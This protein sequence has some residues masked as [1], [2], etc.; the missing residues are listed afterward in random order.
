MP[1]YVLFKKNCKNCQD[2]LA[3][4]SDLWCYFELLFYEELTLITR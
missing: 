3:F 4:E 2:H 1:K